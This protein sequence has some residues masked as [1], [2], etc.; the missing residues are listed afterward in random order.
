MMYTGIPLDPGVPTSFKF[1]ITRLEN[2]KEMV[3]Y[4]KVIIPLLTSW[5]EDFFGKLLGHCYLSPGSYRARLELLQPALEYVS[6]PAI[7]VIDWDSKTYF[8][9]DKT[10][11]SRVCPQ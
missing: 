11:W 2:N 6:I 10:D 5:G 9:P 4:R 8:D 1:T 7:L 3:V